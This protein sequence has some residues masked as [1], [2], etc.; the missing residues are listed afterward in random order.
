[1][2]QRAKR[3]HS[4]L[5]TRLNSRG[6][7]R[8]QCDVLGDGEALRL[9][10]GVLLDEARHVRDTADICVGDEGGENGGGGVEVDESDP[11]E[12]AASA[13]DTVPQRVVGQPELP[14]HV[15]E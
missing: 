4:R 1:M 2:Q 9:E 8:H 3:Q 5:T 7:V 14:V 15:R 6:N 10:L 11:E 13:R 12:A